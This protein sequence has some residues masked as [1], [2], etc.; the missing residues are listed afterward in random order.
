MKNMLSILAIAGALTAPLTVCAADSVAGYYST[1]HP[2]A[3]GANASATHHHYTNIKINNHSY[4]TIYVTVPGT[5]VYDRL[6]P[7][8]TDHIYNDNP[9]IY[10]THLRILNRYQDNYNPIFDGDVCPRA[11]LNVSG[12]PGAYSV[13]LDSSDC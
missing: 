8:E 3:A 12:N 1:K 9:S 2:Q 10:W 6:Y 4:D 7:N 5:P 11:V 13:S